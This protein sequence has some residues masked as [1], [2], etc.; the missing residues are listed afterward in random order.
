MNAYREIVAGNKLAKVIDLPEEFRT[1]DLE[2]LVFPAKQ[3]ERKKA[4][5]IS[6][7]DLPKHDMGKVFS[8]LDRASIYL[9]E[10]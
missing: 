4:K 1:T 3:E 2:I 8:S 7:K 10:R 9:N 5:T 6:L